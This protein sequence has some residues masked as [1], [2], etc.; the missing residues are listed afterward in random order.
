M[1]R[2]GDKGNLWASGLSN[3]PT[4]DPYGPNSPNMGGEKIPFKISAKRL[5]IGENCQW[6][7]FNNTVTGCGLISWTVRPSTV[8]SKSPN[9][10]QQFEQNMWCRQAL[11]SSM[12]WRPSFAFDYARAKGKGATFRVPVVMIETGLLSMALSSNSLNL[13]RQTRLANPIVMKE[14]RRIIRFA[15]ICESRFEWCYNYRTGLT[16]LNSRNV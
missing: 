3:R 16:K 11:W 7:T 10:R 6:S 15:N 14:L 4:S 5:E 12:W 13:L 9:G 8:F 2:C 1:G